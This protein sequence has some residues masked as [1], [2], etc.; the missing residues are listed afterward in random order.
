[1]SG[2]TR[3]TPKSSDS[4]N[5]M[6]ASMTMRSS[7]S[8]N[9]IMFMPN[10]PSPPRG[11]AVRVCVVLCA[12]LLG[13]LLNE[14]STPQPKR[15]SYHTLGTHA[16]NACSYEARRGSFA[17]VVGIASEQMGDGDENHGA[18]CGS[19]EGIP[20]AATKDFKFRENPAANEG[21]DQA[22]NDVRDA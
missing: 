16:G 20:E 12:A 9:T 19:S 14:T 18:K 10:S 2:M 7:P 13:V 17:S 6:P 3:S 4:G 21:T 11:M 8:R 1:M 15:A 22:E 5:I